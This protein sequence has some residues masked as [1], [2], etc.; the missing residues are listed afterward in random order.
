MSKYEKFSKEELLALVEKQDNELASKKYGL[1]WDSERE[2][3]QVV[4][5]CE[6]NLPV[7]KRVKG[8]EIREPKNNDLE[9][10]ILIEGDNYH[11]LTVLNYTHQEKIDVI[12]I[13]PPYNTGAQDWKYNNNYVVTEDGY[14]HSKWLNMMEKRLNL[15]KKL[16]KEDGILIC[17]IDDNE[18]ATLSLLFEK[19]FPNKVKNNVVIVHNPHGVSRSGF[20]R[21]H[22]YAVFIL[23][24]SQI[25]NKKLAPEDLRNIN[26]R[27]SGNNSLR[28]DSPTMFYPIF[29]EKES[30]KIIGAGDVPDKDFHPT[31]QMIERKEFYELWPIDSKNIEKNWYYSKRR[32]IDSG[33]RELEC[34][35]VK[36]KLQISFRHSNNSEQT[37]KTV[38]FGSEYDAGAYGSTLVKD[39]TSNTFPFPK[40]IN[41]V[42]DC[43]RAVLKSK[44]ALILDFFAGSGTTGQAVLELNKEDGGNRKFILCTNNEVNGIEKELREKGLSEKDIQEY[45][46]CRKITYP[47]LEKVIKGYKKNGNGEKVAGLGGNLQYFKTDLVKQTKNKDQL[48]MDLTHECTEMLCV[49]ENIFNL[50]TEKEDYKIFVS[51]KGDRFLCIYYNLFD[52]SFDDFLKEMKKLKGKKMVYMFS[53]D[54]RVERKLFAGVKDCEIE[55]IPQKIVEVYRQLVKMNIPVKADTIFLEFEKANK[56]IFEDKDKDESARILRIVLEKTIQKI[57]QKNNVSIFRDN[58]KEEKI[59]VLNDQLKEGKVFTKVQWEENKTYLTIG[60][61]ASHGD[62]GEYTIKQVENFYRHIQSLLNDFGI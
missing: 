17:A 29:I 37:Y 44:N 7:L 12:Y 11:A 6:H 23:N 51:N 15:A 58:H 52:E 31:Q 5:D 9:D 25:I 18:F 19:I 14:R 56:K 46:I 49:K 35:W 62:Y 8:K 33:K 53:I 2:P 60:N 24:H 10:N 48:R 40:S 39:I 20:S 45:G 21:T 27:R 59:A 41:T 57:A 3:E 54:G 1:V 36:E 50:E 13:D 38:W 28:K 16:L 30:L 34:R 4:L 32:V 61:N 22:E 47:R 26:L 43:L 55:E 42:S